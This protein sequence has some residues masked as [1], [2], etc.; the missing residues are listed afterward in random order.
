[1]DEN[2]SNGDLPNSHRVLINHLDND[3]EK[4]SSKKVNVVDEKKT[5]EQILE[6][7]NE[8]VGNFVKIKKCSILKYGIKVSPIKIEYGFCNTCDINLMH[9]ICSASLEKCHE[10]YHHSIKRVKEPNNI[11][12]GC[13]ERMHHFQLLAK[14]SNLKKSNKCPY[15]ELCEKSK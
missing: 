1:M 13:G 6:L 2:N 9:P 15:T 11:I 14:K 4:S 12:C 7:G 5:P 10:K 8:I 3:S